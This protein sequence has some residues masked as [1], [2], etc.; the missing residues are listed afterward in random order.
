M[1][2]SLLPALIAV[3][4][5]LLASGAVDFVGDSG[6]THADAWTAFALALLL[7]ARDTLFGGALWPRRRS[8]VRHL[9]D[10]LVSK[11][12]LRGADLRLG[13]NI[14]S[15]EPVTTTL[16]ILLG[17]LT[18]QAIGFINADGDASAWAWTVFALS[19]FLTIGGRLNRRPN[20]KRDE[21]HRAWKRTA[22]GFEARFGQFFDNLEGRRHDTD[23]DDAHSDEND[24]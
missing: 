24:G 10:D 15:F 4:L 8:E 18:T 13:L 6:N 11:F 19:L 3:L 12:E 5:G 2:I 1:T 21:R 7:V 9:L 16:A 17:L 20:R 14:W 22:G 23:V